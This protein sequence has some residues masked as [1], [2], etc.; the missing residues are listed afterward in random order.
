MTSA[1]E[2]GGPTD[3][4]RPTAVTWESL[5]LQGF[6]RHR[7]LTLRFPAGLAVWTAPN[8]AGKST[9]ALGLVATVWGLPHLQDTAGFTWG[10]WRA[11]AGGPHVG[12]ATLLAGEDRFTVRRAFDTHRVRVVRHADAGDEIVWEGDHNPNARREAEGYRDWLRAVVGIDDAALVLATFVVAQGD[13]GGPPH[14]VDHDVQAL[15]AGAGGGTAHQALARLDAALRERTRRLRD[16]GPRWSRDGRSDQAL[17]R[18]EARARALEERRE[19]AA[20]QA[21]ALA[22]LRRA[23]EEGE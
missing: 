10:R 1:P 22:A 19:R 4:A 7:D 17:E 23:A 9:A 6:G 3:R 2:Q 15:V 20:V 21:D 5:R 16:L 13:L 12:E 8:E 14:R 11:F 18:A